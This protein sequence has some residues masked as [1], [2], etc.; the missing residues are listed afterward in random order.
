MSHFLR[1]GA[2]PSGFLA[3][4][5][6][7]SLHRTASVKSSGNNRVVFVWPSQDGPSEKPTRAEKRGLPEPDIAQE[8]HGEPRSST[9]PAHGVRPWSVP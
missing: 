8:P 7:V 2:A 5:G 1:L 3:Q 6:G 4:T 9:H